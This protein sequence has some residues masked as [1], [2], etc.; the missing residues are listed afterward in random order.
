M[1]AR[2]CY[3]PGAYNDYILAPSSRALCKQITPEVCAGR[4]ILQLAAVGQVPGQHQPL[5]VL[6]TRQSARVLQR[7]M[8]R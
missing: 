3:A 5:H 4:T 6:L 1:L 2:F 8:Y 7:S